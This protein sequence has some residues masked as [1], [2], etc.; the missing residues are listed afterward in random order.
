MNKKKLGI[1][2]A[3][4]IIFFIGF[5]IVQSKEQTDVIKKYYQIVDIDY[6]KKVDVPFTNVHSYRGNKDSVYMTVAHKSRSSL[7]NK[8]IE[9][10]RQTQEYTTIFKSKFKNASV[11]GIEVNDDWMVWIDCDEWGGYRNPYVMNL[12]TKEI[13]PITKEKDDE[14]LNN[15]P[16]LIGDYVA[17]IQK[18]AQYG[19]S[20]IMLK[21]LQTNETERIVDL[22]EHSF[23][24]MDLSATDGKLLFTDEKS[25]VGYLYLYDVKT[26]QMKE[27][28]TPYGHIGAAEL[29]NEHQWIY[30]SYGKD[31]FTDDKELIFYDSSTNTSQVL[32]SNISNFWGITIDTEN[33]V[34]LGYKRNELEK[35]RVEKN[36]LVLVETL[37]VPHVDGISAKNDL[38]ILHEDSDI[39]HK[40]SSIRNK[41]IIQNNLIN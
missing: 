31:P 9:Y 25:N 36:K 40:D 32:L 8:I 16:T 19:R 30:L 3:I 22:T 24:N 11:Q 38:Y 2:V 34:Y 12:H 5:K 26:K 1:I 29:I 33:Q 13:Q 4:T 23:R 28:K 35:Y 21:N 10:N 6:D 17:W 7:D 39:E 41:I 27:I 15:F 20:S 37:M 14:F 18:D